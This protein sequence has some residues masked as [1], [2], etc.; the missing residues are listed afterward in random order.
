MLRCETEDM[1]YR[2][3]GIHDAVLGMQEK[4]DVV[5]VLQHNFLEGTESSGDGRGVGV[6]HSA[7]ASEA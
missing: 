3:A 7:S 5:A 4:A 6:V 1:F 2:R